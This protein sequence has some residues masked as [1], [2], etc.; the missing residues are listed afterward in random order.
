[1]ILPLERESFSSGRVERYRQITGQEL[2]SL[3]TALLMSA[4]SIK[5]VFR[6]PNSISEM[7][8]AKYVPEYFLESFDLVACIGASWIY[9]GHRGTLGAAEDGSLG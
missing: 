3:P 1:M 9:G 2:I 7:D 6:M 5:S 8:G 4:E